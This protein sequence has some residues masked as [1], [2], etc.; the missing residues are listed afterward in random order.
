[1]TSMDL[2]PKGAC[3]HE[4]F[5]EQA[6]RNPDA[7]AV[8]FRDARLTY[9]DLNTAANRVAHYLVGQGVGPDTLVGLCLES[10]CEMFIGLLG[11][12]KA[13]GAYVPID[14]AYPAARIRHI[15]D[16]TGIELLLTESH[17]LSAL[18]FE[19]LKV[20]PLD[21]ELRRVFLSPYS[22]HN[23][24]NGHTGR[25]PKHLAYVIYTSGSTGKPKGVTVAH[26][27]LV[28]STLSRF[29]VYRESPTSFALFSSYAFDSS[30][31]GIFW[32]L[33]AAGK[34]CIVDLKDGLDP[35]RVANLME[36]EQVSHFLVLPSVYAALLQ[37]QV[38]AP[39]SLRTVIVAGEACSREL[40]QR[41]RATHGWNSRRLVNEY[42]PTEACVWST[43]Y[44]CSRYE[45][46]PVPIGWPV[47]HARLHV[48][49]KRMKRCPIGVVGELYI[50]GTAL[51]R[52]YLNQ[53]GLTASK[54]VPR[55]ASSND[56]LYRTGDLV[57]VLPTQDGRPGPLEF[58]GRIDRQVKVRGFRIEPDEIEAV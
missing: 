9:G 11:I 1:M 34:L 58:L 20:L 46:G 21:A 3:V 10:S 4:L 38:P 28:D 27:S 2:L 50:G 39:Q 14:P 12:L 13:G 53:A 40:V 25:S 18:A 56:V 35:Q 45:D 8:V 57:R 44:D 5:E 29:T 19:G 15:L 55:A 7:V 33:L 23:I 43:Y 37:A 26:D 32:T 31:A 41:H 47:P 42:G 51:A 22:D 49:D 36:A 30:V 16:D 48:L 52:G 24:E 54:F 17:L 6:A